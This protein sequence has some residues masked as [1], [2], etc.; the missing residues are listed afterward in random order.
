MAGPGGK[1]VGKI[2]VRVLPD[3]SAFGRSLERYLKRVE[4]TLRVQIRTE[5]DTSQIE[6]EVKKVG[7]KAA[8]GKIKIPAE[9]DLDTTGF[10]A[11]LQA[12]QTSL[13]S[14]KVKVDVDTKDWA[15]KLAFLKVSTLALGAATALIGFPGVTQGLGV[16]TQAAVGLAALAPAAIAAAGAIG[17]TLAV[18]FNNFG[19]ALKDSG[20][21]KKFAADLKLLAPA[22]AQTAIAVHGIG[23]SFKSTQLAVQQ[24]LFVG[25]AATLKE[26]ANNI[27]PT[28]SSGLKGMGAS[29]NGVFKGIAFILSG[30]FA[31]DSLSAIFNNTRVAL[32]QA[33]PS[34]ALF[35]SMFLR[36]AAVGSDFLPRLGAALTDVT[37]RL[38]IMVQE[39]AASG[40]LADFI[41][42]A[43]NSTTALA[44]IVGDLGSILGSVFHAAS[45][46]G[47]DFFGVLGSIINKVA[48]F[49]K[50]ASGQSA[51]IAIFSL[52]RTLGQQVGNILGEALKIIGPL[53]VQIA[54]SLSKVAEVLGGA[55]LQSLIILSPILNVLPPILKFI[56]DIITTLEPVLKPLATGVLAAA[57]AF[58][59]LNVVLTILSLNPVILILIA[60]AA[61][62]TLIIKNWGPIAGFFAKVGKAIAAPF[63][64]LA[65]FFVGVGEGIVAVFVSVG[66]FLADVWNGVVAALK[67]AWK[68][69]VD[70]FTTLFRAISDAVKA[71]WDFISNIVLG[72]SRTIVD[73]TRFIW[74]PL[75]DIIVNVF[76]TIRDIVLIIAFLILLGLIPIWN[77]I[78]ASAKAAWDA[79]A[80]VA[81]VAW[82][83]ITVVIINPVKFIA[84]V[85]GDV[86][87][88]VVNFLKASWDAIVNAVRAAWDFIANATRNVWNFVAD[89]IGGPIRAA[90]GVVSG[91]VNAIVGVANAAWNAVSNGVRSA[92][93][94]VIGFFRGVGGSILNA[95]GDVGGMLF[96]AGKNIIMGLIHGIQSA[97]KAVADAVA[98]VLQSV[99]NLLPFS[100]AKKG[101]FSGKG[102]TLYSG[103]SMM[104]ALADG[105][106]DRGASAVEA[107]NAVM[108]AVSDTASANVDVM[109]TTGV[110]GSKNN[111][112][113]VINV[114]PQ[115]GQS[116]E[117]IASAAF[118]KF[119]FAGRISS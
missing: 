85:I 47:A 31:R 63:I 105:I 80:A 113:G 111:A 119:S 64:G 30:S 69:V 7:Q 87:R 104:K 110:V 59:V 12:F 65:K 97:A 67:A 43:L 103:R 32:D 49:F 114:F 20:D 50:S 99:R 62:A 29:L 53:I 108:S 4:R 5:L 25:M 72:V 96:N 55:L 36:L 84:G 15:S 14:L 22:A 34:L 107:M 90:V 89:A 68:G 79:I 10:R 51:L 13:K 61:I 17:V 83:V 100:P 45:A 9:P 39:A 88:G 21:P 6:N 109:A 19:K 8:A 57:L 28:V 44:H 52:L 33:A 2:G 11:K 40:R 92:W 115:P 23:V 78:V 116:E 91:A 98:G 46:S 71:A 60:I 95:L 77:A 24:A 93:D 81:K 42:R 70:F 102:W 56:A 82:D 54:P 117:A 1:T 86:I 66:R 18:G 112:P 118:R 76:K 75:V 26:V 101:P 94:G 37:G 74:A 16:L 41:D 48:E 3:T 73:S 58:G 38:A 27:L 106:S 35:T